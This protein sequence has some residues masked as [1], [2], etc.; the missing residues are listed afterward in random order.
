M[1]VKHKALVFVVES[2][3]WAN[4]QT[5]VSLTLFRMVQGG[6]GLEGKKAAATGFSSVTSWNVKVSP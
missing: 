2:Y 6:G 3:Y 5:I 1:H 4:K